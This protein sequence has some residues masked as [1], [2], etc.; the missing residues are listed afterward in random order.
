[1]RSWVQLLT[2]PTADTPGTTLLLHF[3]TKRY[4][5][6]SLAE[7]TQ[8][9]AV[10]MGARLLKIGEAFV[11]GRTEWA[12]IGGLIG[13]VL[14][15][16]EVNSSSR[17]AALDEAK[18]R[19]VRKAKK[20]GVTEQRDIDELIRQEK[21][22][23]SSSRL[24]LVGP[25]NL[26]HAMATA[27]R[28]VFRKGMP[29]DIHEVGGVL[30]EEASARA[31]REAGEPAWA[32]ENIKV[33]T[34]PL[35]S[36]S[37]Q[38]N[39]STLS[40]DEARQ[41]LLAK[42]AV[43]GEMFNSSWRLDTLY[44]TR[45]AD[46][47]LPATIFVRNPATNRIEQYT[48]P[49]P[50]SIDPPQNYNPD[51]EVLVRKPW[52]GA[53]IRSLPPAEQTRDSICYIV[54]GHVQRGKFDAQAAKRLKVR[55]GPDFGR[56]SNG[57]SVV[58][59]DGET[60]S[61]DQ[62]LEP[63]RPG[64]GI[65]VL[66][67]PDVSYID[68]LV[69]CR[70]L[71]DEGLMT[72]IEAVIWIPGEGVVHDARLKD[73]MNN[74]LGSLKH[75][76]S[77]PDTCANYISMDSATG[78]LMKMRQVDPERY[79][80]PV[81]DHSI[82]VTASDL[83]KN[84]VN[85]ERGQIIHLEPVVDIQWNEV[86]PMLDT[87]SKENFTISKEVE[88]LAKEGH[89][90][91]AA[92]SDEI[93][94][95][96]SKLPNPDAEIVPLGTGSAMPS[97]Y[98][99]VSSTLV[100][101]P[102]WGSML[103]DCGENTVGQLKRVYKP[104]E[105]KDV[106]QNL[107]CILISHMHADH[108]LGLASILRAWYREVHSENSTASSNK[109]L[110]IIAEPAMCSWIEEYA[111]LE[112]IGY[113]YLNNLTLT[114]NKLKGDSTSHLKRYTRSGDYPVHSDVIHPSEIGLKDLQAA[115]VQHCQGA[116]AYAVTLPSGFKVSYSGDCRPSKAF[117]EVGKGSTVCIHEATF[118]DELAGDALAKKHS[119]TSEAL[120]VAQAMGAKT[121][122]LTHFSQR[123]QKL[124]V[125]EYADTGNGVSTTPAG[126]ELPNDAAD[127][128]NADEGAEIETYPDQP[129]AAANVD[130]DIHGGSAAGGLALPSNT[131]RSLQKEARDP[132]PS[133][134]GEAVRFKLTTDMRV[135]SAHDCMRIKVG[136]IAQTQYYI[137]ALLRLFADEER[138]K[139]EAK[140][141]AAKAEEANKAGKMEKVGKGKREKAKEKGKKSG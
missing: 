131:T 133:T 83:G 122:V 11:T 141:V 73:F 94:T 80:V 34:L 113:P 86:P 18:K 119:T 49:L 42:K 76:V 111:E 125:L 1:M 118:D 112:D 58:N 139:G 39:Q 38:G 100:R 41:N 40:V 104:K 123:Y 14:T 126:D 101:V 5:I 120:R 12:N 10:Q 105:L 26:N 115:R 91:V 9:A 81:H 68:S 50:T 107:R 29:L 75:V 52:P 124:P 72:G 2:T 7:G 77:S 43:V 114:L 137:P 19:A 134:A 37:S 24:Q 116:R 23:L 51:L 90:K 98:R 135:A 44:S 32:D 53:L 60:V 87:N 110:N 129:D 130:A 103:F 132:S 89:A 136:E 82:A 88:Q 15:L 84:V 3:D 70:E 54:K 6:G 109:R 67:V 85:A 138:A 55:P 62:V 61:P 22:Q 13:M 96:A 36:S 46:V 31:K 21:G 108:H 16:A 71:R 74:V 45:L 140:A 106:L 35:K 56:L 127:P 27:R 117:A 25:P 92:A 57:K 64:H 78:A 33:W 47:N 20:D 4:V 93:S 102:G 79:T 128:D 97:K 59:Q 65:A 28:F 17:E 63:S 66:D 69:E 121:C 95:W 30:G 48:G 99:N 8:R